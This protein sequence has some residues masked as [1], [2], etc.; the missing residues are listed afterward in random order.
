MQKFLRQELSNASKTGLDN[1]Q[2][3]SNQQQYEQQ[4]EQQKLQWCEQDG[5][6][7]KAEDGSNHGG[8]GKGELPKQPV[9]AESAWVLC[10]WL[11]ASGEL[12]R[13]ASPVHGI[14]LTS[15][16]LMLTRCSNKCAIAQLPTLCCLCRGKKIQGAKA[17]A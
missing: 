14:A 7:K 16:Y 9:S 2:N 17:F 4:F 3:G 11:T 5:L 1:V 13:Q 15:A 10:R 8:Q 12:L 6:T